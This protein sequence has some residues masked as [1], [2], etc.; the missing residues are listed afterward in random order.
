MKK[1]ITPIIAVIILLLITMALAVTAWMFLSGFLGTLTSKSFTMLDS[2]G[3]ATGGVITVYITPNTENIDPQEDVGMC[4]LAGADCSSMGT[5]DYAPGIIQPQNPGKLLTIT[6]PDLA[7]D[8]YTIQ[9]G[10]GS[11]TQTATVTCPS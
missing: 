6:N 4:L 7:G 8:T 1:G 2:V 3:C 9:I 11:F 5:V 10:M